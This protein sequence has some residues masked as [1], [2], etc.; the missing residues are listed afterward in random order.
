MCYMT[1]MCAI[2]F[3]LLLL[4]Q[5]TSI[6]IYIYSSQR[7]L[8]VFV[9]DCVFLHCESH[10]CRFYSVLCCSCVAPTF[11]FKWNEEVFD[12]IWH[13]RKDLYRFQFWRKPQYMCKLVY[14]RKKCYIVCIHLVLTWFLSLCLLRTWQSMPTSRS[15]LPLCN[16]QN[17]EPL[18]ISNKP[19]IN[20]RL[21]HLWKKRKAGLHR[22]SSKTKKTQC[23]TLD[24]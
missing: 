6:S 12:L 21:Y 20:S 17:G 11:S 18:V 1:I 2:L 7:M 3:L 5:R 14:D 10:T 9:R 24:S 16:L 19:V 8:V 4:L 13:G 15:I 23:K 22:K